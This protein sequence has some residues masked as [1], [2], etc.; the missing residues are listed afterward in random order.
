MDMVDKK[1]DKTKKTLHQGRLTNSRVPR[2]GLEPAR[3]I[4]YEGF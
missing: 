3:W 2:A 1:E 4:T